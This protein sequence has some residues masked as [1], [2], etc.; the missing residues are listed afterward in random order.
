M[1]FIVKRDALPQIAYLYLA[2]GEGLSPNVNNLRF[3]DTGLTQNG[4]PIY[5]DET[6]VYWL[7]TAGGVW[8]ISTIGSVT[9]PAFIKFS[10]AS[11]VGVYTGSGGYSGSVTISQI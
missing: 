10:G 8:A 3:Y 7:I 9:I 11:P 4:Q 1:A 6:N 2:T 5:Y